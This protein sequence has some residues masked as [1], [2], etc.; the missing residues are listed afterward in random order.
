MTV[1]PLNSSETQAAAFICVLFYS[2]CLSPFLDSDHYQPHSSRRRRRWCRD[3]PSPLLSFIAYF[4]TSLSVFVRDCSNHPFLGLICSFGL[5]LATSLLSSCFVQLFLIALSLISTAFSVLGASHPL[6]RLRWQVLQKNRL[7]ERRL[8]L[9]ASD[10]R[11]TPWHVLFSSAPSLDR[12]SLRSADSLGLSGP[13]NRIGGGFPRAFLLP[14]LVSRDF[15][16]SSVHSRIDLAS[17]ICVIP[18]SFFFLSED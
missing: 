8:M 16:P 6:F 18:P 13:S 7:Y 3:E 5:F 2:H 10:E 1:P 4:S 9:C 12:R 14:Q 15:C 11:E 17:V